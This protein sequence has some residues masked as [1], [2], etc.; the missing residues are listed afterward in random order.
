MVSAQNL[1][2]VVRLESQSK[3]MSSPQLSTKLDEFLTHHH[4]NQ[5][6]KSVPIVSY[7]VTSSNTMVDDLN[8]GH[9]SLSSIDDSQF[10]HSLKSIKLMNSVQLNKKKA[11]YPGIVFQNY[12]E[13]QLDEE[14]SDD[15]TKFEAYS[16]LLS[17]LM[18]S[19]ANKDLG[20][21]VMKQK[22]EKVTVESTPVTL[23]S[24]ID[25]ITD[26]V[27]IHLF[28]LSMN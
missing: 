8:N 3:S 9:G 11:A 22:I 24:I 12:L 27:C 19:I 10:I 6:R 21:S 15:L 28:H 5:V 4:H 7:N 14:M 1:S 25:A 13:R 20:L 26:K 16:K 2:H 23:D 17:K 18:H